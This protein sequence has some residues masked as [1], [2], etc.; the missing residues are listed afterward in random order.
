MFFQQKKTFGPNVNATLQ[1]F[2]STQLIHV[3]DQGALSIAK[4]SWWFVV[5]AF[6]LTIA[7]FLAWKYWLFSSMR[8]QDCWKDVGSMGNGRKDARPWP[9]F[10][11]HEFFK[12]LAKQFSAA[13]NRR[14]SG[15]AA[16]IP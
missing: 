12:W 1:D 10:K 11:T 14:R 9:R 13:R 16:D 5:V 6:P 8:R 7:T 2:F 15:I 4:D 3:D